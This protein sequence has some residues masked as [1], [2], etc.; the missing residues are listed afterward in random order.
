MTGSKSF[1]SSYRQLWYITRRNFVAFTFLPYN[2]H[3]P[4]Q[5]HNPPP[6]VGC[7]LFP[8]SNRCTF[9]GIWHTFHWSQRSKNSIGTRLIIVS[10]LI[11]KV[12]LIRLARACREQMNTWLN[13]KLS[14]G[15][16]SVSNCIVTLFATGVY[17]TFALLL[18]R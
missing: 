15:Q 18:S 2:Q 10:Y 12:R 8:A 3:P 9:R 4:L 11:K 7:R 6:P 13:C 16:C 5:L 14:I 17:F 1:H